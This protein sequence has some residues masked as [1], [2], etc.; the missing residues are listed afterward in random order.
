M[1]ALIEIS[2]MLIFG[3]TALDYEQPKYELIKRMQT[4]R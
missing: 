1:K 2:V 4:S 3:A